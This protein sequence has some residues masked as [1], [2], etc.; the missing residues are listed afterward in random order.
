MVFLD[1]TTFEH[2]GTP[3]PIDDSNF[4][5]RTIALKLHIC[6]G[7]VGELQRILWGYVVVVVRRVP[8][9]RYM[10]FV[11]VVE[12]GLRRSRLRVHDNANGRARSCSSPNT[13]RNKNLGV[14][15]EHRTRPLGH[16]DPDMFEEKKVCLWYGGVKE[17]LF[18]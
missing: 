2:D 4:L 16:A 8:E 14:F 7:F 5:S 12:H 18:I 11:I 9:A 15:K 1:N 3:L 6:I 13:A 10:S 17:E